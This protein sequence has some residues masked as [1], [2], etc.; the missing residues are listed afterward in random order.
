[1]VSLLPPKRYWLWIAIGVFLTIALSLLISFLAPI[2]VAALFAFAFGGRMSKLRAFFMF[3]AY[4]FGAFFVLIGFL[5]ALGLTVSG[6]LGATTSAI[7]GLFT[8]VVGVVVGAILILIGLALFIV[9]NF[10]AD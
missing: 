9:G 7:A 5:V 1:M 3:L 2:I 6:L 10:I 4:L 8:I